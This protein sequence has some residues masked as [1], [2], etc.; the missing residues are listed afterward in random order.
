MP[1]NL[2]AVVLLAHGA[3]DPR[4]AEPF[5]QVANEVRVAAPELAVAVAYLEHLPPSCGVRLRHE[6]L[7]RGETRPLTV[8]LIAFFAIQ[9][10]CRPPSA[11]RPL[12]RGTHHSDRVATLAE[13][14][15]VYRAE[16]RTQV[17]MRR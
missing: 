1:D 16:S 3:R 11:R 17:A 9:Q 2:A 13:A 5:V 6:R 8:T 14:R 10:S 12:K 15:Q 7:G 4:W